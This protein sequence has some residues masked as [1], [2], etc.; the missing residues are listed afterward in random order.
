MGR[1]G[2]GR[3][4]AAAS[5][6]GWGLDVGQPAAASAAAASPSGAL[7]LHRDRKRGQ[8]RAPGGQGSARPCLPCQGNAR[9]WS[10]DHVMPSYPPNLFRVPPKP[11]PDS[12]LGSLSCIK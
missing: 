2:A 10:A 6:A 8:G 4:G 9:V 1:E 3:K 12:Y 5:R 11:Y 7:A